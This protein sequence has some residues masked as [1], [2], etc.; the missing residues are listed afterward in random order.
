MWERLLWE[1]RGRLRVEGGE[2][3]RERC[4]CVGIGRD[5]NCMRE[6][7]EYASHVQP[8]GVPVLI[9]KFFMSQALISTGLLWIYNSYVL[10]WLSF[11]SSL[12]QS[13]TSRPARGADRKLSVTEQR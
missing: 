5:Q 13:V 2:R 8:F 1:N 9:A 10:L 11:S 4:G 6:K 7:R 12:Y 3:E